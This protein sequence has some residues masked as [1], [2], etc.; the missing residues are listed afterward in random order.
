MV[1]T[2]TIRKIYSWTRDSFFMPFPCYQVS[3]RFDAG[4]SG[5]PV[6]D[7]SGA[8]CGLVCSGHKPADDE[9]GEPISYASTLWPLFQLDTGVKLLNQP[10]RVK[11]RAEFDRIIR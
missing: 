9:D 5:G 8:I 10:N 1:S 7:E 3:A 11:N 4:M 2:G 6:F